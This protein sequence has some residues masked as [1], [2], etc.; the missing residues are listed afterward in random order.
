[1]RAHQLPARHVLAVADA[2]DIQRFVIVGCSLG[3]VVAFELGKNLP[4]LHKVETGIGIGGVVVAL[5]AA[6]LYFLHRRGKR[7][8]REEEHT[9]DKDRPPRRPAST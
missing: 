5:I 6:L 9:V 8:E 7:V 1:V 4:L 3:G 2:L